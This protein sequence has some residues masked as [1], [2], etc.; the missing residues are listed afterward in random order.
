[1]LA[2]IVIS[3]TNEQVCIQTS[4]LMQILKRAEIFHAYIYQCLPINIQILE[5]N[6]D[7]STQCKRGTTANRCSNNTCYCSWENQC[8]DGMTCQ[9]QN[10][11]L[12]VDNSMIATCQ[13]GIYST[14]TIKI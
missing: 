14:V 8:N 11:T 2:H 6:I 13:L 4:A 5:C 3:A 9:E 10:Q 7:I 12:A 1:M